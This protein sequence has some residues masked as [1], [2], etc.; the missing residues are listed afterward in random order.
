MAAGPGRAL[1]ESRSP[2]ASRAFDGSQVFAE[3][4]NP[5]WGIPSP[6]RKHTYQKY[7]FTYMAQKDT[8]VDVPTP[9]LERT[10]DEY[11]DGV[12]PSV[13]KNRS[14]PL[15][16]EKTRWAVFRTTNPWVAGESVKQYSHR[17]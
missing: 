12:E 10:A 16:Y 9:I 11:G 17:R 15:I 14:I 1:R 4:N 8:D 3:T 2:R 13:V 6:L 7:Y 5:D